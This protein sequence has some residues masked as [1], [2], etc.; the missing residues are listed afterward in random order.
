MLSRWIEHYRSAK[1]LHDGKE[2]YKGTGAIH[3]AMNKYGIENFRFEMLFVFPLD[4]EITD[5]MLSTFEIFFIADQNTYI[6]DGKGY[7]L[8]KGGEGMIPSASTRKKMSESNKGV[9]NG[10]FG[11]RHTAETIKK[12]QEANQGVCRLSEEQLHQ[13]SERCSGPGNPFY[14][15]AHSEEYQRKRSKPVLCI[16]TGKFYRS[17]GCAAFDTHQI[18][19]SIYQA[20]RLGTYAGGFRWKFITWE[21]YNNLANQFPLRES[22]L[23]YMD[24]RNIKERLN[25]ENRRLYLHK[26]RPVQCIETGR[27]FKSTGEVG[28]L[29]NVRCSNITNAIR[30]EQRSCGLHWKYIT[31]EEYDA[32]ANV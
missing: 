4:I 23:Q 30:K 5:S 19:A 11:K 8:T 31:W 10:F 12:M 15:K 27:V 13:Y 7:N 14:G 26:I 22:S 3:R 17:S 9:N 32:I 21:E 29:F 28:A 24:I 2:P 1:R 6:D 16:E 20:A 18:P 25:Q